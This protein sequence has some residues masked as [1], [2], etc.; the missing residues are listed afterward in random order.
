MALDLNKISVYCGPTQLGAPDDLLDVITSFIGSAESSL[1]IAVQE[2]DHPVIAQAIVGAHRKG[3]KIRVVLEQS[4]MLPS[5]KEGL[6]SID[7][8]QPNT[9][10]SHEINRE[11]LSQMLRAGISL[12]VD[13]NPEIFHQKFIIRDKK[14]VLTGST[15]FTVTGVTKNFNHVIVINNHYIAKQY[16]IEFDEIQSGRF[17]KQ[18]NYDFKAPKTFDTGN[19]PTTV[20]FAPDHAPE[21]VIMKQMLKAKQSIKFAIFTF[22]E[23][24]GIDDTMKVLAKSG[25]SIKGVMDRSQSNQKWAAKHHLIGQENIQLFQAGR[26]NHSTIGKL[27]HKLMVIDDKVVIAGSFNY[28]GPANY[29]ND[30]NIIQIGS[31]SQ[32]K[33]FN[34]AEWADALQ[35]QASIAKY[36]SDEIDRIIKDNDSN[37]VSI[38]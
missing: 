13:F 34:D 31:T 9:G 15:N 3:V 37:M 25:I 35:N 32:P 28:T 17:G 6:S 11:L 8:T 26:F 29:I 14:Q 7:V 5:S 24:S 4:Y 30:E 12:H 33:N 22:A 38:S 1:D 20:L 16:Q 2:I 10:D 36:F 21:M 18:S 27:H 23:S 19:V